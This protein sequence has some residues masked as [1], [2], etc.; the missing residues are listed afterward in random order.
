MPMK[1]MAMV[2]AISIACFCCNV[3]SAK[4][5]NYS[6][7]SLVQ[8]TADKAQE[9]TVPT[10][11]ALAVVTYE[12][13]WN[14]RVL[15]QGNYG[16]GQIRCGTAKGIGLKGKCASLL[17]P[18]VNLEY[19]MI[20]L[21]MALDEADND[22]CTALTLYNRGLNAVVP[23][24]PTR[25]CRD[26]MKLATGISSSGVLIFDRQTYTIHASSINFVRY[27]VAR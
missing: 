24:K 19:S 25:Y 5:E 21:R 8:L 22:W 6:I 7:S 27:A 3:A 15:S 18:E 11:L 16:L 26:I 1:K 14:A 4:D 2:V 12:S 9:H 23:K 20:Y 10:S 17:T 13:S